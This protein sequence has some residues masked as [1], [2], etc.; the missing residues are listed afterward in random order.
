ME[1]IL[2]VLAMALLAVLLITALLHRRR[3]SE[4]KR[5]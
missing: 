5:S 1:V 4:A 2:G 3:K